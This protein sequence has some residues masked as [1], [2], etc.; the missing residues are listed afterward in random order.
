MLGEHRHT[1]PRKRGQC[2]WTPQGFL[3]IAVVLLRLHAA[4]AADVDL[5]QLEARLQR[6][7]QQNQELAAQNRR[8]FEVVNAGGDAIARPRGRPLV[9]VPSAPTGS[10]CRAARV[11]AARHAIR[12]AAARSGLPQQPADQEQLAQ[13]EPNGSG[14]TSRR[15]WRTISRRIPGAGVP[16]GVQTGYSLGQ[17]SSSAACPIPKWDNW[18]DDMNSPPFELRIRGRLQIDYYNFHPTD[19]TNY[20]T[21]VP[22]AR[23]RRAEPPRRSRTFWKSSACG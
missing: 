4:Q 5:Q 20:Q 16:Y 22:F 1:A 19:N 2:H 6:L 23:Q 9:A 11:S 8:L 21:G 14:R 15:S 7:E 18:N 10:P 3:G 12:A 17:A 13:A